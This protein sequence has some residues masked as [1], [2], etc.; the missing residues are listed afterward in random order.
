M[1]M[2]NLRH[3]LK[4]T[5]YVVISIAV[6]AVVGW[7]IQVNLTQ[8]FNISFLTQN[9]NKSGGTGIAYPNAS[10]VDLV[11]LD[12]QSDLEGIQVKSKVINDA[13]I[14]IIVYANHT[15]NTQKIAGA[16]E[17]SLYFRFNQAKS[18]YISNLEKKIA[19]NQIELKRS[20]EIKR[21]IDRNINAKSISDPLSMWQYEKNSYENIREIKGLILDQEESLKQLREPND[22]E[23]KVVIYKDNYKTRIF[24]T[25]FALLTL[26]FAILALRRNLLRCR[27]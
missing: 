6:F 25:G 16:L 7:L 13:N 20:E 4:N 22:S 10:E 27:K 8:T 14:K 15:L 1:T 2:P 11:L 24:L 17:K 12:I 26:A 18:S 21:N 9:L 3:T 5:I 19:I 23:F